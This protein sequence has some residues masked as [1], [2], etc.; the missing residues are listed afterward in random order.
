MILRDIYYRIKPFL[1]RYLQ[2]VMRR[3]LV[4]YKQRQAKHIWPI[5]ESSAKVP[6]GWLGW[7][8]GKRLAL[9]LTHDVETAKGHGRCLALME[10][11]KEMGF[12]S[13]FNFVPERYEVDRDLRSRLWDEGFEV[14]VHGLNHDGKL[15]QS[16]EIFTLRVKKINAYIRDWKAHGFRSPAMHHNLEWI[17]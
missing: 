17:K 14:G 4:Q 6:E 11:E 3:C 13:S 15:F 2:I 7:P 16:H 10:M 5:L 9:V 1:P 8:Q 12:R